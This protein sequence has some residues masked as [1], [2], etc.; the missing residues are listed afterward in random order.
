MSSYSSCSTH[1]PHNRWVGIVDLT[2]NFEA[3]CWDCI[4]GGWCWWKHTFASLRLATSAA[5]RD[6][7]KYSWQFGRNLRCVLWAWQFLIH[8]QLSV[9]AYSYLFF[10]SLCRLCFRATCPTIFRP[11]QRQTGID[12]ARMKHVWRNVNMLIFLYCTSFSR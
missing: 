10:S 1:F 5:G 12:T 2:G 11:L 7:S 8:I 4:A 3:F 6:W 9:I